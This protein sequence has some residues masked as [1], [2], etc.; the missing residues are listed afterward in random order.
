[1]ISYIVFILA[2]LGFIYFKPTKYKIYLSI[3]NF[4]FSIRLLSYFINNIKI[5]NIQPIDTILFTIVLW[6]NWHNI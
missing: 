5:N 6:L 3:F 4:S 2:N 1:M